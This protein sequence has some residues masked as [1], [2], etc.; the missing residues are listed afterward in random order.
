MKPPIVI[1]TDFGNQ[2]PYVGIM[3]GVIAKISPG[4]Q[5]IDLNHEIAPGNIKQ[6]SIV[7]WQSFLYFP[8]KTIF[9]A[10]VDPGVGTKRRPIILSSKGYIFIGPDNGIFTFIIDEYSKAW[11]LE[12]QKYQLPNPMATFHGRDIFAPAAAFAAQGISGNKFGKKISRLT[13]ITLP[14]LEFSTPNFLSGETLYSDRFGNILTSLGVFK[15]IINNV[16]NFQSWL[17]KQPS[18]EIDMK[19][20]Q[21][22]INKTRKI[23]W[24]STFADIPENE[25]AFIVGSSGL[26]EIVLNQKNAATI[27]NIKPGTT[28]ELNFPTIG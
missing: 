9:L 16:F 3:K 28:I 25:C 11:E 1:L 8:M 26:I 7:L 22:C 2:D 10:V 17:V 21:L 5:I 19:D 24:A 4:T 18:F 15:L 20:A 13:E 27:L 12:N 23:K 14:K 6:A